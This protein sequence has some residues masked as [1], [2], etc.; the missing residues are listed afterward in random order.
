MIDLRLRI[1]HRIYAVRVS[2]CLSDGWRAVRFTLLFL[3]FWFVGVIGIRRLLCFDKRALDGFT[4][5][6]RVRTDAEHHIAT[7][8][9]HDRIRDFIRLR[10]QIILVRI[11]QIRQIRLHCFQRTLGGIRVRQRKD[12]EGIRVGAVAHAEDFLLW[13]VD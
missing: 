3:V 8:L 2:S 9:Q 11:L 5:G 6:L 1:D 7:L 4:H 12:T 10:R 13:C